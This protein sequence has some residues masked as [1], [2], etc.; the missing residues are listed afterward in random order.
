MMRNEKMSLSHSI[1]HYFKPKMPP[2][3]KFLCISLSKM[4]TFAL[5]PIL[6]FI[7]TSTFELIPH[8][9]NTKLSHNSIVV[10]LEIKIVLLPNIK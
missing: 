2:F 1:G 10:N 5:P 9:P 6:G 3:T 7:P 4:A 8:L